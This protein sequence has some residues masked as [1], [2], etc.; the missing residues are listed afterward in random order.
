MITTQS[1]YTS[2][3]QATFQ[4]P[5][6]SKIL[7]IF[8]EDDNIELHNDSI[9]NPIMKFYYTD[10][11]VDEAKMD[12]F[13]KAKLKAETKVKDGTIQAK[14]EEEINNSA[15]PEEAKQDILKS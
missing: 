14:A 6:Y 8:Y 1:R 12:V 11:D 7:N 2:Y 3:N 9:Y 13:E 15:L 5:A 10:K 4:V